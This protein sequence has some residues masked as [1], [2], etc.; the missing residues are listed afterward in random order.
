[1]VEAVALPQHEMH[2]YTLGLQQM[3]GKAVSKP[4]RDSTEQTGV[5]S[6]R[7][8]SSRSATSHFRVVGRCAL[9]EYV[10]ET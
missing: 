9:A 8:G 10:I 7:K 5:D 6:S 3:T 4:G 1:M 2:N